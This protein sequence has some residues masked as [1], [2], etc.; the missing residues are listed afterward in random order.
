MEEEVS[1]ARIGLRN[2]ASLKLAIIK[3]SPYTGAES[4]KSFISMSELFEEQENIK[5]SNKTKAQ[6]Q[7]LDCHVS[8]LRFLAMT[9]WTFAFL[10]FPS[11][12]IGNPRLLFKD[13][14]NK[15]IFSN[16]GYPLSRV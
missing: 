6:K 9:G 15:Q 14:R 4:S 16:N 8:A 12:S 13:L 1:L 3:A 2:D 7:R 11:V 10:S 5:N